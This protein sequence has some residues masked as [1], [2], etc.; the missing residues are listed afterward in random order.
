ML[1]TI[2]LCVGDIIIITVLLCLYAMLCTLL[3]CYN[4]TWVCHLGT[5]GI[6]VFACMHDLV[7]NISNSILA[8]LWLIVL[9]SSCI[10]TAVQVDYI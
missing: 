6:H 8:L 2:D 3:L 4:Y 9:E 5:V 7:V 1:L 10:Y